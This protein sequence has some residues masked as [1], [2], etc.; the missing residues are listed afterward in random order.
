[1][2]CMKKYCV[3]ISMIRRIEVEIVSDSEA[4]AIE[5]IKQKYASKEINSDNV[6]EK[7]VFH[8]KY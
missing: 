2:R 7:T 3:V 5:H 4:E 1:M 8:I 6:T